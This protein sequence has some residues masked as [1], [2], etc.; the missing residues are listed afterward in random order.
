[1]CNKNDN[2][3]KNDNSCFFF[4][5]FLRSVLKCRFQDNFLAWEAPERRLATPHGVS[6]SPAPNTK[7]L[8][9]SV[10]V[11]AF[12][13]MNVLSPRLS[14]F[15]PTIYLVQRHTAVLTCQLSSQNDQMHDSVSHPYI[16][17]FEFCFI[18]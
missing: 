4:V 11:A 17:F 5:N 18:I 16:H 13:L 7:H 10:H 1:M 14:R 3:N 12:F 8:N 6:I 9:A 15:S 2:N